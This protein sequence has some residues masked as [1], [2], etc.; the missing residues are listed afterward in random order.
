[1]KTTTHFAGVNTARLAA[2]TEGRPVLISFADIVRRPGVWANEILPRLRRRAWPSVILDS[3]AFTVISTPQFRIDAQAYAAFAAEHRDLFDVIVNLDDI[4]GNLATT[5]A[6]QATLEA[7]GVSALPVFH[8][9]EDWSVLEGYLADHDHVGVGFARKPGGRLAHTTTENEAFLVEFFERVGDRA[10]VHGFAM[11]SW[12]K[13][14]FAFGTVDSTSWIAEY[15]AVRRLAPYD[16][17]AGALKTVVVPR[18]IFV[19]GDLANMIQHHG[20]DELLSLVVDSYAPEGFDLGLDDDDLPGVVASIE[21]DS[22]G[23]ART[24]FRRY[25]AAR[26]LAKLNGLDQSVQRAA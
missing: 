18:E 21:D 22:R 20:P 26:L 12:V 2:A 4:A 17:D 5:H 6:N 25:G 23:Q 24:V 8:Q 3:G 14:G 9:G 19:A 10:R 16:E 7:A 1:M 15:M 13:K 11:T